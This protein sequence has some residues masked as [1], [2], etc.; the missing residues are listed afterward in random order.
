MG[1][2]CINAARYL[3]KAEPMEV[4]GWNVNS[5]DKR[6]K[7]VPE[8]T[9]GLMKFPNDRIAMFTT[10]FGATDRSVFEV[11]GTKGVLKMD[12][13]Y[14]MAEDLKSEVAINGWKIKQVFK[15][16]DQFAPELV[17]F[18]DCILN[19]KQPEP[20]G[21]EGLADVRVVEALLKSAETNRPVSIA[22]VD[23]TQ[24]PNRSQE[25]SKKP[26]KPPQLVRA[27]APGAE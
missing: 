8:M 21:R 7:E 11:I 17:Y 24:R 6:F 27:A 10:S 2:Y 25:I 5:T 15:K 3:F 22:Q 18:S 26:I 9:S 14:E 19:D 20:S 23:L 12:P 16:R 4:F 1:V 13:A